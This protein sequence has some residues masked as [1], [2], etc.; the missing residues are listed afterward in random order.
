MWGRAQREAT[1]LCAS[2]W[3]RNLGKGRIKIPLVATSR[4]P[5]SVSLAYTARAVLTVGGSTPPLPLSIT[6]FSHFGYPYPFRR[7]SRSNFEVIRN[8][9]KFCTFL[10][11]TFFEGGPTKFWDL[12]YK[13]EEP[14]DHLAKFRSD[15]P[16]EL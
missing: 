2:D 1:R 4:V 3:G 9:P 11:P 13:T 10:A 16:T 14:S 12:D 15:R 8:R 7:Y 5:N 6:C